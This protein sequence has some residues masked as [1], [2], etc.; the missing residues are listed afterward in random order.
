MVYEAHAGRIF[1]LARRVT[2][3][4]GLAGDVVKE[5]FV[6]LWE[7][8]DDFDPRQ[9]SLRAHLSSLPASEAMSWW[10]SERAPGGGSAGRL[11]AG[12]GSRPPA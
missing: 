4:S 3:D 10:E 12:R 7:R 2:D 1:S 8:P 9:G 6:A 5:V 11:G